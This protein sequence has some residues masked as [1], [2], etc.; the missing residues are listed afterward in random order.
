[1]VNTLSGLVICELFFVKHQVRE[2]LP[3]K[4]KLLLALEPYVILQRL[5]FTLSTS[6]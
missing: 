4:K 1:M 5:N 6:I 3:D 2:F